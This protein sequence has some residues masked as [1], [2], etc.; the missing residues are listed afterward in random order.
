MGHASDLNKR[1][2]GRSTQVLNSVNPR[3]SLFSNNWYAY[4]FGNMLEGIQKNNYNL[5]K[6]LYFQEHA[7]NEVCK[8][9]DRGVCRLSILMVLHINTPYMCC[10]CYCSSRLCPSR[11]RGTGLGFSCW[12][13]FPSSYAQSYWLWLLDQIILELV[14]WT[15]QSM[16]SFFPTRCV[17]EN[18]FFS[19]S[20]MAQFS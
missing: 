17:F 7:G 6:Y 2:L 12:Y 10:L 4:Y 14:S 19:F 9:H 3:D 20:L 18:S 11:G 1:T 16:K 13:L 5:T 15:Q 8:E